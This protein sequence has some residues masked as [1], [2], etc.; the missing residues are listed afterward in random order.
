MV[1]ADVAAQRVLMV[2]INWVSVGLG[3]NSVQPRGACVCVRTK[4]DIQLGMLLSEN[5]WS[6]DLEN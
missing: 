2:G 6:K 5:G 3:S 1:W 4:E